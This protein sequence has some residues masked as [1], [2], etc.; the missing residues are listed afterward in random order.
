MQTHT[1]ILVF[2]VVVCAVT[3]RAQPEKPTT[4]LATLVNTELAFARASIEKGMDSAFVAFLSEDAVIFRPHPVNGQ[5]WFRSHPAPPIL[6]TWT[7]GFADVSSTGDLGYTTGPWMAR[8]KGDT[9]GVP[10][11]GDFVTVWKR[12][13][14]NLWKVALDVGIAHPAPASGVQF[15]SG[16][17]EAALPP[18]VRPDSG[19]RAIEWSRLLAMEKKS[20]GD[21]LHRVSAA[22]LAPVLSPAVR[23]FRPGRFPVL[24][25]DSVKA[26][27]TTRVGTFYRRSIAGEIS[28]AAD[29][30]YT[31]GVYRSYGNDGD[32]E[33]SGYYLSIWK[34]EGKE[35]WTIVLD[36]ESILRKQ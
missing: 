21:S 25:W 5:Q 24:G 15:S 9:T 30:G 32:K 20:F 27:L 6:L 23:I 8:D 3:S 11:Y 18:L 16:K 2:C 35:N 14:D 33:L 13:R 36:F 12:Q 26:L 4:E 17:N 28:R 7:P 31:Y 10:D 22:T 34:K 19:L 29:L 1:P